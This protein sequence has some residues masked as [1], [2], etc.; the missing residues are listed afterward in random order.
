LVGSLI[1][2]TDPWSVFPA[3][4]TVPEGW[5]M[6]RG[7]AVAEERSQGS[8]TD[9]ELV[10]RVRGGDERAFE[11]LVRRHLGMAHSVACSKLSGDSDDADD[12]CQ[13]AFLTALERI[14]DCRNPERF[15]AWLASIVRNKAHNYRS[16]LA[17]RRGTPLESVET[18]RSA[19]DASE[20][21]ERHE[22]EAGIREAMSHLTELQRSVF[23]RFDL[24]GW[25]HGE[26]AEDLGISAG[27]SRFH[28]HAARRSL[29]DRL[30]AYP[31]SWSR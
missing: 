26:I 23:V 29:R 25:S 20:R 14:E 22:I 10:E 5:T 27:A 31:L 30:T 19:D 3:Q 24:E 6:I 1:L 8:S 4:I 7:Y 12:V 16:Y 28:L 11:Q 2:G 9:A 17:V 18:A 21:V 13:E 15:G